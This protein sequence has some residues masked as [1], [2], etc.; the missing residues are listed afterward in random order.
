MNDSTCNCTW[1]F[2]LLQEA[3]SILTIRCSLHG[4]AAG[5]LIT[6]SGAF[7]KD[8]DMFDHLEFGISAKDARHMFLSTRKL[9]EVGFTSLRDSG[10]DYRGK[11]VG[12]Y[13]SGVAHDLYALSGYVRCS[14]TLLLIIAYACTG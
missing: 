1:P 13:L 11:N 8:V 10:I 4:N 6:D 5:Q 14:N 9:I 7:L 3:P 12:C 2:I